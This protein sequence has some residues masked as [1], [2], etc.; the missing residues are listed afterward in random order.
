[1]IRPAPEGVHAAVHSELWPI[2]C[3]FPSVKSSQDIKQA[4][5]WLKEQGC[6]VAYGPM[7]ANT[8][9]SY[10]ACMGPFERPFFYGEPQFTPE[11]WMESKYAI[12]SRYTSNLCSNAEETAR[13]LERKKKLMSEGWSFVSLSEHHVSLKQ[14]YAITTASFTSA[15]AYTTLDR[16]VFFAMYSPILE[17]SDP[18]LIRFAMSPERALVGYCYAFPDTDN[19]AL[20][21]FVVK[22]LAVLPA[23]RKLGVGGVLV[24]DVHH[25]AESK[26]WSNGG[27]HALM[28]AGS[29]SQKISAH[30][31]RKIRKYV[32]FSKYL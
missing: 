26:G 13:H 5:L 23:A 28:W 11:I 9:Y 20:K 3:V 1:M 7:Y 4:E 14:I 10:R 25:V 27:I 30:H 8:L 22:T 17:C 19:P 31:G 18:D 15:F 6:T 16:N 24:G 21:Q 29:K 12:V 2:G 32:L